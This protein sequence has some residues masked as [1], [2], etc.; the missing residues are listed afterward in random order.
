MGERDTSW[1]NG[2]GL[3]LFGSQVFMKR[4]TCLSCA[5]LPCKLGKLVAGMVMAACS[6][7]AF[8]QDAPMKRCEAGHPTA[9]AAYSV[10][11]DA[12]LRR[13]TLKLNNEFS[14]M[15]RTRLRSALQQGPIDFAGHYMV[16]KMGC[17]TGCLM[18]GMVDA[19]TGQA[20]EIPVSLN[21]RALYED[22]KPLVYRADSRLLLV[23]D[24]DGTDERTRRERFFVWTGAHFEPLC[25]RE[26]VTSPDVDQGH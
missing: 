4:F 5:G 18:A 25:Q 16:V 12:S 8:A 15:F 6:V 11:P 9:F 14:R 3:R 10:Q 21:T 23:R 7:G 13:A 2:S 20:T 19:R 17:G 1:R 26:V 22:D 24:T